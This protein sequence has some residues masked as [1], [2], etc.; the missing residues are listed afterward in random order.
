MIHHAA[1]GLRA[2]KAFADAGVAVLLCTAGIEAVV[3]MD[4]LQPVQAD[5]LVE[6]CQHAVQIMDDIVACVGD[7]AGVKAH[8][9]FIRQRHAVKDLP[10]LLK[11]AAYLRA[12]AGHGLQQHRGA[13]L[14][15]QDGVEG[16]GNKADAGFEPLSGMAAG[17]EVIEIAGQILHTPEVIGQRHLGELTGMFVLGAGIDGVGGVSHQRTEAVGAAQVHQCRRVVGVDGLGLAAPGIAGEKL[18][19]CGA[20]GQRRL[21]HGQQSGGGGQVTADIEHGTSLQQEGGAVHLAVFHR[22][23]SIGGAAGIAGSPGVHGV[24]GAV[25]V[26]QRAMGMAEQQH[27]RAPLP[28]GILGRQRRGLHIAGVAVQHQNADALQLQQPFRFIEAAPVA[29]AGNGIHGDLRKA[30]V[31]RPGIPQTVSQMENVPGLRQLHAPGHIVHR[32]VGIRQNKDFHG[33]APHFAFQC[34][35]KRL[36]SARNSATIG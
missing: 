32:T 22:D 36:K 30:V 33:T 14:R 7:M 4:G 27:V 31:K 2:Q 19:R 28:G 18:H 11:P 26:H 8:A 13:E 24:Q 9:H 3:D 6:L 16:V 35:T 10:Q 29:V 21:P 17:M 25:P 12:F 34:T 5:D 20:D 1:E 23:H 15:R